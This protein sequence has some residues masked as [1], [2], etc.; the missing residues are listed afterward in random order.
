[1]LVASFFEGADLQLF[2]FNKMAASFFSKIGVTLEHFVGSL[3]GGVEVG[4]S[5]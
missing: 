4:K 1:V 3:L 2:S 5:V